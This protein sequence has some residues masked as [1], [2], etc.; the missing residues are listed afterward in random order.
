MMLPIQYAGPLFF[1]FFSF[2]KHV[3]CSGV[4]YVWLARSECRRLY[5]L[6]LFVFESHRMLCL[7]VTLVV[8]VVSSESQLKGSLIVVLRAAFYLLIS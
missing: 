1:Y 6:A 5:L 4:E 7:V 3:K 2:V 8:C